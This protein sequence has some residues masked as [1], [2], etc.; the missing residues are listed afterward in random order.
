M[1][2]II[3]QKYQQGPHT[4]KKRVRKANMPKGLRLKDSKK[5]CFW[6]KKEF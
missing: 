6:V 4:W 1:G 5:G 3:K 2:E